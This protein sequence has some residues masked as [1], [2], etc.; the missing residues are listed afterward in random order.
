MGNPPAAADS[1]SSSSSEQTDKETSEMSEIAMEGEV[2]V[3]TEDTFQAAVDSNEF[4]LVDF[5][6]SWCPPCQRLAPTIEELGEK[7]AN[8]PRVIIAKMDACANEVEEEKIKSYPTIKLIKAGTNE[9]VDFD[10]DRTLEGFVNFLKEETGESWR[11]FE[12]YQDGGKCEN[13]FRFG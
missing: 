6:A 10:G 8:H 1:S 7:F 5:Y 9:I 4:I 2:L 13:S 11:K 3:L 12:Q